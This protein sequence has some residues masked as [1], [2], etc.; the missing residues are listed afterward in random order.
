MYLCFGNLHSIE[1]PIRDTKDLISKKI[2]LV[3]KIASGGI[4]FYKNSKY[5][6]AYETPGWGSYS[7]GIF[8]LKDGKIFLHPQK[9]A[10][11]KAFDPTS[12]NGQIG[13]AIVIL[14]ETEENLQFS[15]YL[16]IFSVNKKSVIKSDPFNGSNFL[17]FFFMDS[18][19]PAGRIRKINDHQVITLGNKKAFTIS[20]VKI[21]TLPTNTS[22]SIEYMADYYAASQEYL[23]KN[24]EFVAIARKFTKDRVKDKENYWYYISVGMHDGVWVFGEFIKID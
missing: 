10:E 6:I 19:L 22:K 17:D 11:D 8:K 24:T 23:P 16:R 3:D 13:E 20:N 12:C 1:I 4:K 5:E 15:K 7:E 2:L 21:R 9:C 18:L 14:Y